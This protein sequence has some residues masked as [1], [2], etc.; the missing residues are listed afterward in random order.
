VS[1]FQIAESGPRLGCLS[2]PI[3]REASLNLRLKIGLVV[4]LAIFALLQPPGN[5]AAQT[6]KVD[7]GQVD[8]LS[9]V[10]IVQ[11]KSKNLRLDVPFADV[12]VGSSEIADIVAI[13]D[14]QLYILGKKIGTTNVLL[15][16]ASKR[17]IGVVDVEVKLDTSS[18]ASKIR[19][20]S[21]GQGINVNDVNGKLVLSGNAGDA[22]TVDRAMNVASALAP[23]AINALRVTTPQQVM[24]K[25][26]FVEAS[27]AAAR[28][29][30]VRWEFFKR[31][32]V[33][34]VVGQQRPSSKFITPP[35]T[36]PT[37]TTGGVT[38]PVL[39]VVAGG[40]CWR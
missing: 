6:K 21:G 28:N 25:V 30:G 10:T 9:R 32:G 13:S 8:L 31:G 24:L 40:A 14:R 36:F 23:G 1:D 37:G 5:A 35:G 33:A 26:R 39:D 12:T 4:V 20:G 19:E 34:G 16:D 3:I 29:L 17:L 7:A 15:Y 27:R 18:L 22:Q 38:L 2:S 11:N